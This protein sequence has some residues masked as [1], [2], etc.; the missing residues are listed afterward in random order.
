MILVPRYSQRKSKHEQE[1]I[2]GFDISRRS[3][4]FYLFLFSF[5]EPISRCSRFTLF[6]NGARHLGILTP[7]LSS[8]SKTRP[9]KERK[10]LVSKYKGTAKPPGD[11]SANPRGETGGLSS[12]GKG[13]SSPSDS[14]SSDEESSSE[15]ES[16]DEEEEMPLADISTVSQNP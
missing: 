6:I 13:P 12:L 11:R 4:C 2:P 5:L 14:S 3:S 7:A 9:P 1:P 16:D 10:I 8:T 15:E